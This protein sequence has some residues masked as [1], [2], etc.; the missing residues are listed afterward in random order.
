MTIY[1]GL[2]VSDKTTHVCV[3]DGGGARTRRGRLDALFAQK[4]E[5][6]PAMRPLIESIEALDAQIKRSGKLLAASAAADPVAA[7]LMTVP[8]IGPIVALTYK[9]SSVEPD[10]FACGED[11]GAFAGL[12]PR[13]NL[14]GDR[15]F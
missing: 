5:R 14:S 9:S 10:R 15:V 12:V 4:P 3:V 8:S 6:E 7:R 2:D 13:R 1:A 11:A